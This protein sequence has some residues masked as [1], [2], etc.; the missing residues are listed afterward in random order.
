MRAMAIISLLSIILY[1]ENKRNIENETK[2]N[3]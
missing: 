3:L 1:G 2:S